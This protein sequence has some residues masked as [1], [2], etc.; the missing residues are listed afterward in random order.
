MS[1]EQ[2]RDM[3]QWRLIYDTPALGACN[4]AIDD[5]ILSSVASG[6]NLPTLRLYGWSCPTLSLGYG[7]RAHEA[8]RALLTAQGVQLV[9]RPTG[10]R[11]IFH[12]DELT[13]SLALPIQHPLA[14]GS[15][16]ESYRKISEALLLA[17]KSLGAR[18][19]AERS[20]A[21]ESPPSAVCFDTPSHYEIAVDG[22]KLV[23]SAQAR[24]RDGILQH[25]TLPLMSDLGRIC[26]VLTYPDETTRQAAKADVRN[27]ASTLEQA[28]GRRVDWLTAADAVANGFAQAFG[29]GF[30]RDGLH[31]NERTA[32]EKLVDEV[33][34]NDNWTFRR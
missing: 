24:R 19:A 17:L 6:S 14:Q 11:A 2:T 30:V 15:V 20:A 26:D 28:L 7:Q 10:G 34:G 23:G 27:R 16:V 21:A 5:A 3:R 9:R 31:P 32:A 22:R 33:Y 29:I 25:G 1:I 12:A 8:D 4:M 18:V 13:Y